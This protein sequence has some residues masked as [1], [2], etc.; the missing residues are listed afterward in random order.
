MKYIIFSLFL[1]SNFSYSS[2]RD[3]EG[4]VISYLDGEFC[5]PKYL[6]ISGERST[7]DGYLQLFVYKEYREEHGI[8]NVIIGNKFEKEKIQDFFPDERD[9]KIT[10]SKVCGLK[11]DRFVGTTYQVIRAT[12]NS[13]RIAV[14]GEANNASVKNTFDILVNFYCS[15]RA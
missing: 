8:V 9:F 4:V 11:V 10:D 2:E 14:L 13:E 12:K 15:E 1:I 3:C 7:E 5:L 6:R